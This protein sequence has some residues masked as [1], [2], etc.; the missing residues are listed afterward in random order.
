MTINTD[1]F[2]L[3]S[4]MAGDFSNW[5]QA[6]ENPPFFAHIRVCIRPIPS[7]PSTDGI[8]L[9]L[10]QAY[11]YMLTSPYRSAVLNLVEIG[12]SVTPIQIQNYRLKDSAK[13]YGGAREPEKLRSLTLAEMD[14]LEG[15]NMLVHRHDQG[16]FKGIVEPGKKCCVFRNGKNSYLASEFEVTEY[17][18]SSLDRGYD[19]ETEERIWGSV[20]GAFDFRKKVSFATEVK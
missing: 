6:I 20:A 2:T 18:Y 16:V 10:E 1:L 3:A 14:K 17:T 19:P 11:D 9:Y 7:P 12:D 4:W 5:D 8:W 15:C 13:Y